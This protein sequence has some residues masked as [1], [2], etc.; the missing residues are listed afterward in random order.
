MSHL[1][2]NHLILYYLN[3]MLQNAINYNV[4]LCERYKKSANNQEKDVIEKLI[5]LASFDIKNIT[6]AINDLIRF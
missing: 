5:I 3:Q 2:K 6:L 1:N 4:E